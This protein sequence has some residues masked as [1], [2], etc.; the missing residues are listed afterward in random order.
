[1]SINFVG[2]GRFCQARSAFGY[3]PVWPPAIGVSEVITAYDYGPN[4]KHFD[5]DNGESVP[6]IRI[7]RQFP[8][9]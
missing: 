2:P 9:P 3:C 1:L 5:T 7:Y 6:N 8:C 4:P